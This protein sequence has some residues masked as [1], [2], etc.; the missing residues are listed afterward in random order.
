[1]ATEEHM[2]VFVGSSFDDY[3]RELM[4]YA[5]KS[6]AYAIESMDIKRFKE[7]NSANRNVLQAARGE[8]ERERW[9]AT[10][11]HPHKPEARP[12]NHRTQN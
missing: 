9:E 12:E 7:A 5:R 2:N 3:K 10:T 6:M 4:E 11:S 8:L 1:M